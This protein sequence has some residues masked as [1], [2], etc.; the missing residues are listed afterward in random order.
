VFRV[1]EYKSAVEP[2]LRDDMSPEA[3][4][5]SLE[6]YGDLWRD[7]LKD[8]AAARKIRPED[9]T[10]L[11]EAMPDR[12]RVAGGDLARM[13]LDAK[14]V[15]KLAPRDEVRKRLIDLVGEDKDTKSFR[16]VGVATYLQAKGGDRTGATGKGSAV[17][18]TTRSRRSC[19]AWTAPAGAPSPPR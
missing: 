19:C 5:M 17:A 1:G 8:V 16:Q 4:E 9:I 2:Y 12:L 7:Y 13:A 3:K 6:F 14:M 18:R 11:I 10:S 15:D